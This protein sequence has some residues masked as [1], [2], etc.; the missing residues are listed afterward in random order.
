M[1]RQIFWTSFEENP[2]SMKAPGEMGR[3]IIEIVLVILI[4]I[5]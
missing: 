1:G 3:L 4:E 2:P 5:K